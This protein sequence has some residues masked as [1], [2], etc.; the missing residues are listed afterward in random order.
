[1]VPLACGMLFYIALHVTP[2]NENTNHFH[3]L[4]TA[5]NQ[6]I[7]IKIDQCKTG[8]GYSMF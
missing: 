6:Q 4:F 5:L 8:I 7:D 2:T 3:R 1:M